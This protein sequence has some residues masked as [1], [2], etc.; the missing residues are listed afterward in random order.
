MSKV[1]STKQ[2]IQQIRDDG[3]ESLL[4]SIYFF[5]KNMVFLSWTWKKSILIT[6]NQGK[7]QTEPITST[8]DGTA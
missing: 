3:W 7:R 6:I 1:K 8:I 2:K 5:V 4:E